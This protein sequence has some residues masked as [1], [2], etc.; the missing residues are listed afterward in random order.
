[1]NTCSSALLQPPMPVKVSESLTFHNGNLALR[2][3]FDC[4]NCMM[5]VV[6]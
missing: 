3:Q 5:K 1:M 4:K 2:L 6:K